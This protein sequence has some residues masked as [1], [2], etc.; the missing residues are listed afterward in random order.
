[1]CLFCQNPGAPRRLTGA[2]STSGASIAVGGCRIASA[3]AEVDATVG[4]RW[5]RTLAAIGRTVPADP[6]GV[7]VTAERATAH[8]AVASALRLDGDGDA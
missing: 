1:M 5:R 4:T 3:G 2:P 7:D 8:Q 6:A